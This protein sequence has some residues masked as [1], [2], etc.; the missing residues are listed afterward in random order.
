VQQQVVSEQMKTKPLDWQFFEKQLRMYIKK[1]VP[2]NAADDIYGDV[3]LRLVSNQDKFQ[4]AANPVA[5]M[6]KVTTNIIT[7]YY[8][9]HAQEQAVLNQSTTG[10]IEEPASIDKDTLASDELAECVL[11][12]INN[13]PAAYSEAL[14]MTEIK[15]MKQAD[16]AKKLNLSLSGMKSRVQRGRSLLKKSILRCCQVSVN[17]KGSI[18]DYE[19][20]KSCC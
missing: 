19:Q 3:I 18:I 11:P 17:R 2:Q 15:G 9:N 6:Y 20:T 13:L 8:R 7:D 5:W 10:N 14:L 4:A 12:L 1:R 16:A